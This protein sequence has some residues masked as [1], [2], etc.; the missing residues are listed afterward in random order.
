M[1]HSA[2]GRSVVDLKSDK[3]YEV[4]IQ[5]LLSVAGFQTVWLNKHE[6]LRVN[7]HLYGTVDCLGYSEKENMLLFVNCTLGNPSEK[8]LSSYREVYYY[9]TDNVF[10]NSALRLYSVVFSNAKSTATVHGASRPDETIYV[11]YKDQV[12]A[13]FESIVNGR[14][15]EFVNSILNPLFAMINR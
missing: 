1:V 13:L 4:A 12:D 8:E 6:E 9:F 3:R 10:K 14:E 7:D 15:G 11:Y 2:K 5:W